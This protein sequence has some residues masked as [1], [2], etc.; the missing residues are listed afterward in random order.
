MVVGLPARNANEAVWLRKRSTAKATV[1]L[2][3]LQ[4]SWATLSPQTAFGKTSVRLGTVLHRCLPRTST[5]L[6]HSNHQIELHDAYF[7][8]CMSCVAGAGPAAGS[9]KHRKT[10][11]KSTMC[12]YNDAR[13]S[14]HACTVGAHRPARTS[15]P[16]WQEVKGPPTLWRPR[17]SS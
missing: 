6:V 2:G 12:G 11:Y 17:I 15:N 1:L 5:F 7:D 13:P 14:E 8:A 3:L 9:V 10:G 4:G 16:V